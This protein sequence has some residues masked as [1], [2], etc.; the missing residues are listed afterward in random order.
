MLAPPVPLPP[1]GYKIDIVSLPESWMRLRDRGAW[2]TA[3]QKLLARIGVLCQ[4]HIRRI[5]RG[6]EPNREGKQVQFLNAT[7]RAVQAVQ[8]VVRGSYVEI[9]TD[10]SA[11]YLVYQEYGVSTQPMR[12]L[13]GK[14]IPY[15]LIRGS[16]I[17]PRS[18]NAVHGVTRVEYAGPGS[19][20]MSPEVGGKVGVTKQLGARSRKS[21]DYP[22][23]SIGSKSTINP[24]KG[25]GGDV[26]GGGEIMYSM[27]TEATFTKPS[28]YNPVG[29]KWWHPGYPGKRFFRD[30]IRFG[31]QEVAS[32]VQGLQFMVA[33]S[34]QEAELGTEF[35][36][37]DTYFTDEYQ[38]LLDSLDESFETGAI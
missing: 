8:Y 13:V 7:G 32:H 27:I 25:G 1:V 23:T 10:D 34:A 18:G 9:F 24:V 36:G 11:G 15:T 21:G 5:M 28:K 35:S 29:L 4:T 22:W 12:W 17:N 16:R 2:D 38:A 26:D 19:K 6:E 30:G 33:G 31:L 14:T 3:V 20:Y 37:E